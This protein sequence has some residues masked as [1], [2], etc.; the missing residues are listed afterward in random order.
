MSRWSKGA[1]ETSERRERRRGNQKRPRREDGGQAADKG[2]QS[3]HGDEEGRG[4][5][6]GGEVG[7][8]IAGDEAL[9]HAHAGEVNCWMMS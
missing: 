2:R 9:D 6:H 7:V 1:D 4:E 8:E 3:R 5:P